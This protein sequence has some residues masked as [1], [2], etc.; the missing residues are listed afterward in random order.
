MLATPFKFLDSY[1]RD[2]REIFFGR[3]QEIEELY[4]KVFES[5]I[6]LV[7]GISGTGKSS[8]IDCGLANKFQETDW[9]PVY[10]RRGKNLL[11]S[12]AAALEQVA[13]STLNIEHGTLKHFNKAVRSV[14]LDHYKPIFFIFDQFEELFIFGNAEERKALAQVMKSL[15]ESDLQCRFIISLR[16]EYLAGI[17]EF[18]KVIPTFYSNRVRIEKMSLLNA[19]QAIEGPCRVQHIQLEEGFANALLERLS[20]ESTEVELT[21]L[22][23]ALDRLYRA[24]SERKESTLAFNRELL[25]KVGQVSDLLGNFLDE[26]IATLENPDTAL[27]VLK[28]FVSVKGTKRQMTMGECAGIYTDPGQ[29]H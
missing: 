15:V 9:L 1:T 28:S 4:R 21:F 18:E 10:V 7:Y 29:A 19:M 25:G 6:L 27:A 23:V 16:E 2:D 13:L 11:E 5:K 12:L 14:Y 20:P 24:A 17:T 22:Q 8:L 26:Q 3:E